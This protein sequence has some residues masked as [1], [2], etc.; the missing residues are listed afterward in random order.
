MSH[1]SQNK[2]DLEV[3][4]GAHSHTPHHHKPRLSTLPLK[5]SAGLGLECEEQRRVWLKVRTEL[6]SWGWK[7]SCGAQEGLRYWRCTPPKSHPQAAG[8]KIVHEAGG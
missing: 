8:M 3:T 6:L 7:M 5:V 1:N 2:P 4:K